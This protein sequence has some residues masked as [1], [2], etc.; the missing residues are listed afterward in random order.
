MWLH[1]ESGAWVMTCWYNFFFFFWRG[2]G[3]T[4]CDS[5][6]FQCVSGSCLTGWQKEMENAKKENPPDW[7]GWNGCKTDSEI[8]IKTYFHVHRLCDNMESAAGCSGKQVITQRLVKRN[9]KPIIQ[10]EDYIK[11]FSFTCILINKSSSLSMLTL[12]IH[13]MF[14]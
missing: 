11:C 10:H 9:T 12:L 2:G 1:W 6:L 5:V 14:I 4:P 3:Y 7:R 13:H 8:K